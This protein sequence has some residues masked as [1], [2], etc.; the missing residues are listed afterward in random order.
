MESVCN[1]GQKRFA[2][3][4]VDLGP[5]AVDPC[6]GAPVGGL[7]KGCQ[8][9]PASCSASGVGFFSFLPAPSESCRFSPLVGGN[10]PPGQNT[11]QHVRRLLYVR[12]HGDTTHSEFLTIYKSLNSTC[13]C[14]TRVLADSYMSPST[15]RA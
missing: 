12:H 6:S 5:W 14:L 2:Y 8:V 10:T 3:L 1:G 4:V 9:G 11:R 7:E 15:F 13:R